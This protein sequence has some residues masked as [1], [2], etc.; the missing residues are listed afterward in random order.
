MEKLY[1]PRTIEEKWQRAWLSPEYYSVFK[2]K[3]DGRPTFIIDT[4]PP[5]T[6]GELHMGHAYWSVINDT[7]ARYKRMKGFD[8]LLPQGW[9]TQGLPTELKVQYKWKIPK[10]NRELFRSKC[11]EW[12][13]IM[14]EKMKEGMIKLGYRPDWEQF[15]YKTMD[16]EYWRAVQYSLILMFEK[17]LI[18]KK[19][20]PV[21]WCSKCGTALAQAETGYIQRKGKLYY[22]KFRMDNGYIL[23]GTTRPELLNACVAIAVNPKDERYKNIIGKEVEV[24][25]FG[26]KVRILQDENVDPKFGTGIVMI[27]TYGDEQDIKWQQRYNLPI[28]KAIDEEGRMINAKEYNG[29][30]IEEARERIAK[31]L[32]DLGFLEKEEEILHNV[33]AHTERSDC[34]TPIEFLIKDQ[35]FL[36][37]KELKDMVKEEAERMQWIPK[38]MKQRLI[39]WINNIEWDWVISRQR[40]FGT[41]IPFWYCRNCGFIIPPKKED[42]PVDTTKDK[43][44]INYCPNCNSEDISGTSDV[45]DCW[46]DSSITPL[47]ITGFFKNK[48][49]FNKAY[50]VDVRQ[51]GHDIIR[52]WLYYTVL[53]CRILTNNGP[54]KSVVINGHI[55]GP[56]GSRMSKSKG[57]VIMPEEGISKYGA[58]SLRQALLLLTLGSDFPFRWEPVKY[59]K[60]FLQKLW[61]SVRFASQFIN[62]KIEINYE[63]LSDIDKWILSRLRNVIK[64]VSEAMENYQFHIAVDAL[65]QF[66]WHDF[67]DQYIEAVKP[68]LY[69]SKNQDDFNTAR[70]VIYKVIWVFIRMFA[71]I[72]PHITEEIYHR[73]FKE[74]EK[75][76]SINIAPYP[77]MNEIPELDGDNG[78]K[79]IKIIA[80]LRT[81]KV[82]RR[83]SLSSPIKYAVVKDRKE[84]LDA[85]RRNEWLIK[86]VLH[87]E[88]I[89]FLEGEPS[90]ELE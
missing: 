77:T 76:I 11:I 44:P 47:I 34:M 46:I 68:R 8:V 71:P 52:T 4:P 60:S 69:N 55:L 2:F 28:I 78:E 41:P 64:I 40:V 27:C 42:L 79:V 1:S 38:Y 59:G 22:I 32:R 6:S 19:E 18:Y 12:T 53:R 84:M 36:K 16:R 54:F 63:N 87:I 17:G 81:K 49:I 61:S 39:D 85:Y 13:K 33:L 48:E 73:I 62:D 10:D 9:D 21:H 86:E 3:N 65:Q 70:A 75:F 15:E 83:V 66:Y 45:C 5:F 23:I 20:F 67:C 74:Y 24:P 89:D 58:D 26:Q 51:Q 37:S 35:W 50:P 43:P 7:I 30:K 82:E 57:N 90:L 25:I 80:K 31:D 14:I 56:D 72:C 88:K 29:L